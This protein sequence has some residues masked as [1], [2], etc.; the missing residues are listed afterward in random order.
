MSGSLL[1][2]WL[3]TVGAVAGAALSPTHHSRWALPALAVA[4][5]AVSVRRR[6]ALLLLALFLFGLG[7]GLVSA[8]ARSN[9]G[10]TLRAV[11]REVRYC[12]ASGEV[13]EDAGGSGSLVR[14]DIVT[15]GEDVL[16]RPG[17]V[18][19]DTTA[20]AGSA[21][22][23][24]GWILPLGTDPFD[25]ARERAGAH[26]EFSVDDMRT[27]APGGMRAIAA[28]I[29]T[30]LR[31]A[32]E[33]VSPENAALIRGV[34]IG[35]TEGISPSTI[36]DF[37][38]SGLS[39][40]LAVS[41]SNVAIVL[42]GAAALVS[43]LSFR[44]RIVAGAA[45]LFLFVLVV[46]PDASV[47][48]AAAMGVVGLSAIATGRQAEPLHA[49]GV[50]LMLI[51][52]L[53]PQIVFA[54]G[55]H[56]SL[57]ATAGIILWAARIE[58]HF[59]LPLIVRLPLAVTL[60][61]QVAVAPVLIGVFGEASLVAPITNLL[62]APAVPPATVL[63]LV[64]ALAGV[65]HPMIGGLI[66]RAAEPF[67]SW[68]LFVGR[69]GAEPAWASIDVPSWIGAVLAVPVCVAG[70]WTLREHGGPISLGR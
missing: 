39:H 60:S 8:T 51:V 27:S 45:S 69:L 42:A 43:R 22:S 48:R 36:D 65:A 66:L 11:A 14:L 54:V 6:P 32:G 34:T 52:L 53:R 26:A 49:L 50:A 31:E 63:G 55:L 29:R 1:R 23:A 24:S 2:L 62:A 44:I 64:G 21:L 25:I 18:V 70:V 15:C 5:V 7:C 33:A 19:S 9:D 41:G 46:G 68:I 20:P 56:L 37:R 35:D 61:A 16:L 4:G 40:L 13:L 57:A 10:D 12:K 28:S 47:L 58:S 30:G 3:V 38:R 67:G 59:P 17:V